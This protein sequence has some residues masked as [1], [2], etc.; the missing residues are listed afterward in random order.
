[1]TK[2]IITA[3]RLGD[4]Q[5]VYLREDDSWCERLQDAIVAETEELSQT[6]LVLA[7]RAVSSRLVIDP[8]LFSVAVDDGVIR[9]L[10]RREEIR[11]AGPSV[12]PDLGYQAAAE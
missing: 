9:P 7:N 12:R 10:G 3:N 2:Q 5:V 6:L 4:G 1:M 8:Y 11:A